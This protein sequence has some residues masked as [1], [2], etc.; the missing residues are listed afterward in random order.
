[1][2]TD[3]SH[4]RWS[5][6]LLIYCWLIQRSHTATYGLQ[7]MPSNTENTTG[8]LT[9]WGNMGKVNHSGVL[10]PF[11]FFQAVLLCIE[12]NWISM[13]RTCSLNLTFSS[14]SKPFIVCFIT[15][16]W[17]FASWILPFQDA[18]NLRLSMEQFIVLGGDIKHYKVNMVVTVFSCIMRFLQT[19]RASASSNL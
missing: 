10:K 19:R 18:T 3:S 9:N 17:S 14:Q 13:K 8:C 2:V 16:T 6:G 11:F 1:M 4:F 7:M 5:C 12:L 15:L